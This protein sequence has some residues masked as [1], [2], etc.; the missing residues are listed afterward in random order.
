MLRDVIKHSSW[1][2][3]L[4]APVR[5]AV[6]SYPPDGYYRHVPTNHTVTIHKY[7]YCGKRC[8]ITLLRVNNPELKRDAELE[9][10]YLEDLEILPRMA[11]EKREE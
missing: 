10:V 4:K 1:Y 6:E 3:Q 7:S 5:A 9:G 11:N 8:T 2:Q